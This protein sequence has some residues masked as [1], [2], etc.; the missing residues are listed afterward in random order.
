MSVLAGMLVSLL[1]QAGTGAA[2]S[3]YSPLGA[4][5]AVALS[6][7]ALERETERVAALLRCPVC[8]GL[9]VQDSPTG[10]AR[11][12]KEQVREMLAAGYDE[13]QIL[14]HFETSYGEF[15]RLKPR[16]DGI[17]WIVWLAPLAALALGL[18]FVAWQLRGTSDDTQAVQEPV[19]SKSAASVEYPLP[20]DPELASYVR[21]VREA[22]YGWPDGE[23]P[24]PIPATSDES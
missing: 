2:S 22:A 20:N 9:S 5:A 21:R 7:D 19:E 11:S 3:D 1:A 8:Q 15:V 4:P 16:L 14:D 6:G 13:G 24:T 10:M 23:P 17:N 12:M 18:A